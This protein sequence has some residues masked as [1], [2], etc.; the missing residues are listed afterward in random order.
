[1]NGG[2][3]TM[4]ETGCVQPTT[5]SENLQTE[6]E[7]LTARLG[8]VKALRATLAANPNVQEVID[9]LSALGQFHY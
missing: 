2:L 8:K 6:E 9:G 3:A 7:R 1:M 4:P 5:V